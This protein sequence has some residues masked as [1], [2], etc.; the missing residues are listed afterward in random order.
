[1]TDNKNGILIVSLDF[2]LLWGV[3][4]HETRESFHEQIQGARKSIYEVLS[5]FDKYNIHATWG[6]VGM[7]MA[8]NKDEIYS[9]SPQ[10]KP[11]YENKSLSAYS[12]I[13]GIGN[14]EK[15]DEY[16]YAY[17]LISE[18]IRHKNQEIGSHTFS[19]YYCKEKGQTLETF[20][21]D[22][23]AAKAIAEKKFNIDVKSLII[24]R[25]QFQSAYA[26]KACEAGFL[27]VR[28]NPKGFAYNSQSL[29]ARA[30]RLIDTYF[31]FFGKKSYRLQECAAD[32]IINLKASVFFRKYNTKL[33][34]L[35]PYKVAC[36]KRQMKKAAR[37]GEIFHLW[38]HPHNIGRN[39]DK[40]IEQLNEIFSYYE[41]L[42]CQY[43]FQSKN[44]REVAEEVI[45]E[46]CNAMQCR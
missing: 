41:K 4:D 25:N 9:F 19:H 12:H 31:N 30:V 44:M 17:S 42:N 32:G 5:L 20:E 24:P 27:S 33:E 3:Q 28:G 40:C 2:E 7:L 22:L 39:L 38:W 21:A 37:K 11:D 29:C 23:D 36:I 18:I 10:L 46:N 34:F 15:E 43:G 45:N 26:E 1:M 13:D 14:N 8:E 16:H 35:E 6:T